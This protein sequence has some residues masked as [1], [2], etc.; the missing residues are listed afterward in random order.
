MLRRSFLTCV[1]VRGLIF[2]AAQGVQFHPESIITESGRTII[3]NWL[4]CVEAGVA[5]PA[6]A[7]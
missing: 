5:Q 2:S 4:R 1:A 7:R 6:G 3:R